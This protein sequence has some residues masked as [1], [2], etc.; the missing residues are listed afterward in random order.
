MVFNGIR[1]KEG[2][3]Y[4]SKCGFLEPLEDIDSIVWAQCLPIGA[5]TVG[6]NVLNK[7]AAVLLEHGT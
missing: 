7:Q 1:S 6:Y 2:N 4:E 5:S 3:E